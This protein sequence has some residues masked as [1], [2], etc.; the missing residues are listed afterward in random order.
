MIIICFSFAIWNLACC[1]NDSYCG[2]REYPGIPSSDLFGMLDFIIIDRIGYS[3][4]PKLN[5]LT[6]G[7]LS[8]W[9]ISLKS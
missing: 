7:P 1:P 9:N 4:M 2:Y 6:L 8:V 3:I 5:V